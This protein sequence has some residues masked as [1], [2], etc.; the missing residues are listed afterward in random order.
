MVRMMIS[1]F[2]CHR[3]HCLS[4]IMLRSSAYLSVHAYISPT[5]DHR[6]WEQSDSLICMET[7]ARANSPPG[8]TFAINCLVTLCPLRVS[9]RLPA[10]ISIPLPVPVTI[11]YRNSCCPC[12]QSADDRCKSSQRPNVLTSWSTT[13]GT[14]ACPKKGRSIYSF[15]YDETLQSCL[16]ASIQPQDQARLDRSSPYCRSRASLLLVI[17]FRA[18]DYS[19]I[20]YLSSPVC[21][22]GLWLLVCREKWGRM[23]GRLLD[24]SLRG[25]RVLSQTKRVYRL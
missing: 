16:P 10:P 22:S 25:Q 24:R 7:G 11:P 9:P 6:S 15:Q 14:V 13:P 19:G 17:P 23:N 2:R 21:A 4:E 1:G 8:L 18:S 20:D 5:T 3:C 12:F